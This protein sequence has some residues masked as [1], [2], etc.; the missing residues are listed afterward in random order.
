MS[1]E[2]SS[3]EPKTIGTRGFGNKPR[4][5]HGPV[6]ING[7]TGLVESHEVLSLMLICVE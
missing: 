7:G 6:K 2:E 4:S 5:P 1:G 3:P